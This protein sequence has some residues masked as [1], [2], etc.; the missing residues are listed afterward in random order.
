[1]FAVGL[2]A[3]LVAGFI[4]IGTGW[5]KDL[6]DGLCPAVLYLNREQCCWSR[7]DTELEGAYC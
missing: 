1:M 7:N 4:D 2:G 6:R 5:M 3:G